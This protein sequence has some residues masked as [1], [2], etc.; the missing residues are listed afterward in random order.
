MFTDEFIGREP[1]QAQKEFEKAEKAYSKHFG[2]VL[3][4]DEYDEA[5]KP[6]HVPE[7]KKMPWAFAPYPGYQ[8][9]EYKRMTKAFND[10]IQANKKLTDKELTMIAYDFKTEQEYEELMNTWW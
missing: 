2:L 3:S 1:T 5:G 9:N 6:I 8:D 4:V 7:E 10:A